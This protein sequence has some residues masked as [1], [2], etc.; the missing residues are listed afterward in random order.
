M[1]PDITHAA[2]DPVC[3]VCKPDFVM[4]ANT[5]A[6]ASIV[7]INVSDSATYPY[8][9]DTHFKYPVGTCTTLATQTFRTGIFTLNK[10]FLIEVV[11][12]HY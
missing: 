3:A 9:V 7:N 10:G 6:N 11:Q 1:A 5:A 12:N 8:L 2:L 4:V